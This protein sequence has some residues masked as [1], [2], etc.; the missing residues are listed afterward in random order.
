MTLQQG[1]EL[2][3][4]AKARGYALATENGKVQFQ[5]LDDKYEVVLEVTDFVDYDEAKAL[6]TQND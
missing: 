2:A 1:I 3:Q 5:V 6:M 4:M